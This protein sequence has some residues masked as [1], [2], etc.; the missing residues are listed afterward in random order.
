MLAQEELPARLVVIADRDLLETRARA[1][2]LPL[3]LVDHEG[4]ENTAG[5]RSLFVHHVPLARKPQAGKVDPA[6]SE[7]VLRAI[8][9]AV[10]GCL[11]RTFDALVTGPVHKGVINDAGIAFTGHTEYLGELTGKEPVMMLSGGGLRVALATT[12]VAL[13][14]VPR[15]L[16]RDS[17]ARVLEVLDR[18]L[19]L[20]FGIPHPHIL[21]AGLN[22]HAGE[23]GHLGKEEIEVIVPVLERLREKGVRV[24]GPLPADTIFNRE[25]L[26][27]AD[28]VLAMYHDQGLPVIK[29]ASF[30]GGVNI[31]LGLPIIRTSV[32]HGTALELAGTGRASCK[33]LKAAIDVALEMSRAAAAGEPAS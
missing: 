17:L 29:F 22:P 28:C 6:N 20:R 33:S 19:R 18:D 9:I 8:R 4:K 31:T 24:T 7:Y 14:D 26:Q 13:K 5:R 10:A 11:E 21:V 27:A 25:R 3:K 15:Y 1:L 12:H 32:D 23:G 2:S 16:S 30:G